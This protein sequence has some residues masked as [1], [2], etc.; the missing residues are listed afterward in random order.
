MSSNSNVSGFVECEC[1]VPQTAQIWTSWMPD[2]PGRRFLACKN[3]K[4]G[5]CGFFSWY[6]P[7]MCARSKA[8]IPGLLR[9]RN[10]LE[11]EVVKV[12][13]ENRKMKKENRKV[14]MLIVITWIL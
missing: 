3:Y 1:R 4:K 14:K 11:S 10:Q 5:G 2:N 13:K 8:I 12:K 6:D 7:Q 9:G